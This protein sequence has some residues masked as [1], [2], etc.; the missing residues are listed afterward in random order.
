MT[1]EKLYE[2]MIK[3]FLIGKVSIVMNGEI[4]YCDY[5]DKKQIYKYLLVR[6]VRQLYSI[7]EGDLQIT[8]VGD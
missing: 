4:V 1:L 8:V 6:E 7:E 5:P 2:E 3:P